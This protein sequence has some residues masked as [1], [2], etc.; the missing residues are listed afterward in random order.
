MIILK[1]YAIWDTKAEAFLPPWFLPTQKM[2][3]RAFADAINDPGSQF[4]KHPADYTLFH[5][6]DFD[7]VTGLFTVPP[8]GIEVLHVGITLV[9]QD[10]DPAQ[11]SLVSDNAK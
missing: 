4:G 3:V 9:R 7:T 2:A 8:K 6:G 5:V 11:P 10:K 1:A